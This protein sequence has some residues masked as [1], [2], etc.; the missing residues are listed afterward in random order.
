[1]LPCTHTFCR[2]CLTQHVKATGAPLACPTCHSKHDSLRTAEDIGSLPKNPFVEA[3]LQTPV[4][5]DVC[6]EEGIRELATARCS[7][8]GVSLCVADEFKHRRRPTTTTHTLTPVAAVA[9]PD[10]CGTHQKLLEGYCMTCRQL[11]CMLCLVDDHPHGEKHQPASLVKHLSALQKQLGKAAAP[12][13]QQ[14]HQLADRLIRASAAVSETEAA[15]ELLKC[16]IEARFDGLVAL[17]TAR[18]TRMLA[19]ADAC[20]LKE[21]DK[22]KAQSAADKLR[23]LALQG[24]LSVANRLM[25]ID[26]EPRHV[27]RLAPALCDCLQDTTR[28]LVSPALSAPTIKF[29]LDDGIERVV[30]EAGRLVHAAYGPNCTAAGDGLSLVMVRP[31][32]AGTFVINT[33]TR[34][35]Q[36]QLV[37]GGN[38]VV[39]LCA[40]SS[41]DD[42]AVDKSITDKNDGTYHVIYRAPAAGD[43]TLHITVNGDAIQGSPFMVKA[44]NTG[45]FPFS[46][47]RPPSF[48][49]SPPRVA[50]VAQPDTY[51]KNAPF[52]LPNVVAPVAPFFG[53]GRAPGP[54]PA[55]AEFGP[56]VSAQFGG[57][58]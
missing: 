57:D 39:R 11:C 3:R 54:V 42:V 40:R 21:I 6:R 43:Y 1:M 20:F 35:G 47:D 56:F 16:D 48:A 51:V 45:S 17:L 25:A 46:F 55:S 31:L 29:V 7:Q 58:K 9:V 10:L 27:G 8:C 30:R 23:W 53:T 5:C 13:Q 41:T 19:E 14:Q 22:L 26:A 38:V 28:T 32:C 37:G 36:P 50:Q 34:S 44:A 52:S 24:P 49:F 33:F 12:A 18:K 4:W 2:P 15:R